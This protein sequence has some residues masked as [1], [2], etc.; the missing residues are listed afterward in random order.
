MDQRARMYRVA[1][2]TRGMC[3]VDRRGDRG[4]YVPG[5]NRA[6]V[7]EELKSRMSAGSTGGFGALESVAVPARDEVEEES[8]LQCNDDQEG[9]PVIE[10]TPGPAALLQIMME[11]I[12]HVMVSDESLTADLSLV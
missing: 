8:T 4:A 7:Q 6:R 11:R 12:W 9:V 10:A 5:V 1:E 3:V 2:L